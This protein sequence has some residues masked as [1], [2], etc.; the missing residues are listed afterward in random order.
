MGREEQRKGAALAQGAVAKDIAA[1]LL[2]DAIGGGQ[3]KSRPLARAL[4]GVEGLEDLGQVLGQ[5]GRVG[6]AHLARRGRRADLL[7]QLLGLGR[8]QGPFGPAGDEL[9]QQFVQLA[10]LAGVLAAQ[11]GAPVHAHA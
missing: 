6:L 11:R 8:G 4:G 7:E 3:A 10:D 9:E 2:D 1:G 5:L